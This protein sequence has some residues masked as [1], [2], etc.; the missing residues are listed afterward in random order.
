MF[1]FIVN[2]R[3]I[4][5]YVKFMNK[6]LLRV[7]FLL[8]LFIQCTVGIFKRSLNGQKKLLH[9]SGSLTIHI[10]AIQIIYKDSI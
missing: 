6:R 7:I 1:F 2:I 10:K 4:H 9:E 8:W 5:F 3:E